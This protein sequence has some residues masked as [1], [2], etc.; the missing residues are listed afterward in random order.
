MSFSDD[1]D[2]EI[3]N[4]YEVDADGWDI[5]FRVCIIGEPQQ[6]TG[7]SDT[8]ISDK[9]QFKQEVAT[10]MIRKGNFCEVWNSWSEI[11]SLWTIFF[12]VHCS[13]M[14][15]ISISQFDWES[16]ST[17]YSAFIF[18]R[19]EGWSQRSFYEFRYETLA[20]RSHNEVFLNLLVRLNYAEFRS[21]IWISREGRGWWGW[22]EV[23]FQ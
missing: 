5:R 21:N 9:Q 3:Q 2:A 18:E 20:S 19:F 11:G 13:H 10:K 6:Q 15:I 17:Y 22:F 12:N 14:R 8:G 7:F 1:Y 23:F 16:E 4:T